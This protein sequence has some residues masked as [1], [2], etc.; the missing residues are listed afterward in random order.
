MIPAYIPNSA[1]ALIKGTLPIDC[2]MTTPD[3]KRL[4]GDGKTF[5]GFFGGTICGIACGCIQIWVYQ[6]YHLDFFAHHTFLSVTLLSVG[7]LTGDIV[8]SFFKRR[9][10]KEQGDKWPFVDQYD[11]LLGALI[12]IVI[13]DWSWAH[14]NITITTLIAIVIM[15]P[16][17]HR[18]VN[19]IG[20]KLGFK[21]VPW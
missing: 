14:E 3:G 16:L 4:L 10:G 13:F 18:A 17:L 7:S 6:Q 12:L 15:T 9:L 20:Y 2:G 19:M 5:R 1:A 11:F 8:A 21:K